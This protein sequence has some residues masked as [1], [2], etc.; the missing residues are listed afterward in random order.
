MTYNYKK[1]WIKY[2]GPIPK[3]SNGRS[4]EIH[5]INGDHSDNRLENLEC[6]P[7]A[8]HY[9]RHYDRGDWGACVMIA[10][11]MNMPPT[12]ISNIQKG[13]K[14]PGIGGV[15]KGTVPWNKGINYKL[16]KEECAR[17]KG[18]VFSSKVTI[19]QVKE[20]RTLFDSKPTIS[21]YNEGMVS[22]NG[23]PYS[24]MRAFAKEYCG[25]F[26]LG[27]AGLMKILDRKSWPNV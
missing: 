6:I 27:Q 14:R 26:N 8:I 20:I 5:H 3:E 10:K 18:K 16:S 19:D 7:I 9:Q 25:M 24:Y 23:K 1:L 17:R 22:K 15:K 13:K 4:Y 2:N 11:R 12:F 21:W